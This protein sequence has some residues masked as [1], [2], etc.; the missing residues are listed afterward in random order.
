MSIGNS[1][2]GLSSSNGSQIRWAALAGLWS[3]DNGSATYKGPS[4][5]APQSFGIALSNCNLTDGS[6]SVQV[7]F[8]EI[9]V[10]GNTS[11]GVLLGFQSERSRYLI[12]QLGGYG[13]AYS[14]AEWLP[15]FGWQAIENAGSA[16]N[17]D[18]AKEYEITVRQTGQ[19]IR[20]S[21]DGVSVIE[22]VLGQPLAGNQVGL[23]AW[24][25]SGI[26]FSELKIFSTRPQVFVA[27]QFGLPYDTLYQQVISPSAK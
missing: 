12:A 5:E 18:P 4:S 7:K 25:K 19:E 26:K 8:S 24:G 15:G 22:R 6:I 14:L 16:K 23:F 3:F 27:M 21:V 2:S 11:A 10:A 1:S 13:R 17:L 20:V 9:D